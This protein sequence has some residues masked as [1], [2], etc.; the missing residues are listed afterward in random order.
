MP[1]QSET[2]VCRAV[3]VLWKSTGRRQS[4]SLIGDW[5]SW[6]RWAV[7]DFATHPDHPGLVL[8]VANARGVFKSTD[9]GDSWTWVAAG[10]SREQLDYH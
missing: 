4:W 5:P 6:A 3:T 2:L 8:A 9:H 7:Y 1:T 10:H